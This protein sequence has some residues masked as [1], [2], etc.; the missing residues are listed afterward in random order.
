MDSSQRA[1][2]TLM[3]SFFQ[4]SNSFLKFCTENRKYSNEWR[5]VNMDQIAMCYNPLRPGVL[6]SGNPWDIR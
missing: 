2:K 6:L 5:W 3:N 4:I 1:L